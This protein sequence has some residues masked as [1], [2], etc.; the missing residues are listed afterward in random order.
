MPPLQIM[1]M[2]AFS[3]GKSSFINAFLGE[4]VTAVGALPTTAVITKLMYGDNKVRVHFQ[5][6]TTQMY[7]ADEFIYM[8]NENEQSWHFF[9]KKIAY[10]ERVCQIFCVNY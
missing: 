3:T 4:T 2:G 9:R 6:D 10:V 7:A 8:S 5:D 1:V